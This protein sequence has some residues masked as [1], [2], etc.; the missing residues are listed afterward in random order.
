MST[1]DCA[2]PDT[3]KDQETIEADMRAYLLTDYVAHDEKVLQAFRAGWKAGARKATMNMAHWIQEIVFGE[4]ESE[5]EPGAEEDQ[6]G[7]TND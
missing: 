5:Q 1:Q 2:P 6:K 3:W 7:G 4:K